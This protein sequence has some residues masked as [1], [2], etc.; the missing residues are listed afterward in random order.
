MKII[1]VINYKGGV[2]KTTVTANLGAVLA[3]RGYRVLLIDLDPQASLT[4]SFFRPEVWDRELQAE[5]TIKRWFEEFI[6][7]QGDTK[8]S[9]LIVTPPDANT[10][11]EH[12]GGRLDLIASHLGLINV[13]LELAPRLVGMSLSQSRER[14]LEVHGLLAAGLADTAFP[15]YDI[16]LVDCPPNF[17][18][19]TKTAIV[20]SSHLLVP[21]RADDLSTLGIQFLIRSVDDLL[22]GYNDYAQMPPVRA[23]IS[24]TVL[25][26]VFTM[27]QM[28]GGKPTNTNRQFITRTNEALKVPT[29]AAVLR[30]NQRLHADASENGVPLA[31]RTAQGEIVLE[32]SSLADEFLAKLNVEGS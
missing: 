2:G 25:G 13:D 16:V 20:A 8:L 28:Y 1:S 23:K 19:V 31:I 17:N 6:A 3:H 12:S 9:D 4:F 24:P 30:F 21:S 22:T 15:P 10:H 5:R 18:I 32:L 14:Y 29:F 7:G 11:V 26:V 27:V